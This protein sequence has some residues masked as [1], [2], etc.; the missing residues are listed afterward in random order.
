MAPLSSEDLD[1]YLARVGHA[2]ALRADL[3]TLVALHA[4]HVAA[5]PFENL[6]VRWGREISLDIDRLVAKLVRARRG[7]YCFE[8]N[9][10]FAAVLRSIGFAIVPLGARV[11]F[12]A[13]RTLP[14]THQLLLVDVEGERC[15]ADVGFGSQT[16]LAPMPLTRDAVVHQGRWRYRLVDDDGAWLLQ[17]GGEPDWVD[18]YAFTLEPQLPPD[19]EMANWYVAT[20]PA[21][22]FVRTFTVQ[23]A[24]PHERCVLQDGDYSV[25][26]GDGDVQVRTLDHDAIVALLRDEFGLAFGPGVQLPL[27]QDRLGRAARV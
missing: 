3:G 27:P 7:G 15:I 22:R 9:G 16:L 8:Q 20:H 25:D 13:T 26:R 6:D 17:T 10:L 21:S 12:R 14:R 11:R 24:R 2:D 19:L 1:A 5:I 18:L 23:Q 4:A